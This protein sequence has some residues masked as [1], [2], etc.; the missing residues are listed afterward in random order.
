[1]LIN[2]NVTIAGRRTSVRLEPEMWDA[3]HAIARREA[4]SIHAIATLVDAGKSPGSTLTA[5][6]RVFVMNYYRAAATEEGH[7]RA[8]HGRG[9]LG[10][11]TKAHQPSSLSSR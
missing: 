8:G 5:E 3:L 2:R 1:M 7:A 9:G 4:M 10:K 11:A 6:L